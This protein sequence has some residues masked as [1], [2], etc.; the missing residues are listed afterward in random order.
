M[1]ITTFRTGQCSASSRRSGGLH[2]WCHS[3]R[4]TSITPAAELGQKAGLGL[5]KI[6]AHSRHRSI[7]TLMFYVDEHDRQRTQATL[8]DLVASTVTDRT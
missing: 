8:A 3:L 5:D 2:V 4:H 6:R 7:A 1:A